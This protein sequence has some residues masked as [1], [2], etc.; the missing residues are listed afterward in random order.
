MKPSNR[1]IFLDCLALLLAMIALLSPYSAYAQNAAAYQD[2]MVARGDIIGADLVVRW[3]FLQPLP[4]PLDAV[5]AEVNG[6]RLGTPQIK[7]FPQ[8]DDLTTI[9]F[10]IDVSDPARTEELAS[11]GSLLLG[12]MSQL[13]PHHRVLI[14]KYGTDVT[15]VLPQSGSPTELIDAIQDIVPQNESANRDEA[16]IQAVTAMSGLPSTRRAL[17]VLTD[18][19]TDQS[20]RS[21]DVVATAGRYGV[22]V[23]FVVVNATGIRTVDPESI[24]AI[25]FGTGGDVVTKNNLESFLTNPFGFIDSG[26]EVIF[27]LAGGFVLPWEWSSTIKVLMTYGDRVLELTVPANLPMATIDQTLAAAGSDPKIITIFVALLLVGPTLVLVRRRRSRPRAKSSIEQISAGRADRS[28]VTL[29]TL[30]DIELGVV[31]PIKAPLV[32][33]GRSQDN[34]IALNEPTVGRVHAV[35]QQVGDRAFSISDQ[36]SANGTLVNNKKIDTA[37]LAEGDMITLGSKTLRFH[38]VSKT[39]NVVGGARS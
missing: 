25:A 3:R 1:S 9:A 32:R 21:N 39:G 12:L 8:P 6:R 4:V 11:N 5:T 27:P 28:E 33:I 14:F 38:K 30:E 34:D 13:K 31:Y 26:A 24:F 19:H 15:A 18:G 10:L 35:L 22:A 17:F 2:G 29:A 23:M 16:I 20:A 37:T 36:S 7:S